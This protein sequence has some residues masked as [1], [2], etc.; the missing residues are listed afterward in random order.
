MDGK[1]KM[2][3]RV[4]RA[5]ANQNRLILVRMAPFRSTQY[6]H[7]LAVKNTYHDDASRQTLRPKHWHEFENIIEAL[8][9]AVLDGW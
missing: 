2:A 7:A 1:D 6:L 4:E 8:C 9:I 5:V 3:I